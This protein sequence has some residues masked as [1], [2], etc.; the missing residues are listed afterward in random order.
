MTDFTLDFDQHDEYTTGGV[1]IPYW[2]WIALMQGAEVMYEGKVYGPD[3]GPFIIIAEEK[4]DEPEKLPA[5]TVNRGG[6]GSGHHEHQ[7][8][9]GEVGGSLPSGAATLPYNEPRKKGSFVS[10]NKD[11][12]RLISPGRFNAGKVD[13][14][15]VRIYYDH[16]KQEQKEI[17]VDAVEFLEDTLN[18]DLS[19]LFI[20][21]DRDMY[22]EFRK[23]K[24]TRLRTM[25]RESHEDQIALK[26]EWAGDTVWSRIKDLDLEGTFAFIKKNT[27]GIYDNEG[28][29]IFLNT[30]TLPSAKSKQFLKTLWHEIGH[31]IDNQTGHEWLPPEQ[32]RRVWAH[33]RV[34]ANNVSW[35]YADRVGDSYGYGDNLRKEYFADLTMAAV[36]SAFYNETPKFGRRVGHRP[37]SDLEQGDMDLLF[38]W[39]AN[40]S[41]HQLLL[42]D[43]EGSPVERAVDG[44]VMVS[45]EDGEGYR[46][47]LRVP[48]NEIENLPDTAIVLDPETMFD[49]GEADQLIERG[50]EGSGHHEHQGRPGEVGGSLPSGEIALDDEGEWKITEGEYAYEVYEDRLVEIIEDKGDNKYKVEVISGPERGAFYQDVYMDDLEEPDYDLLELWTADDIDST[51]DRAKEIFGLTEDWNEAGYILDDG[52]MLDFSGKNQGGS[53]GMRARDHREIGQ[54]FAGDKPSYTEGMVWFMDNARAI[55][56]SLNSG[57]LMVDFAGPPTRAQRELI[58]S[59]GMQSGAVYWDVSRWYDA[60]PETGAVG[61]HISIDSGETSSDLEEIETM[62]ESIRGIYYSPDY[63]ERS[64]V[65]RTLKQIINILRGGE[66][67]GHHGHAGRQGEVGGSLPS[68]EWKSKAQEYVDRLRHPAKKKYGQALIG[69]F[70]ANARGEYPPLPEP[71]QVYKKGRWTPTGFSKIFTD[72]DEIAPHPDPF[73]FV[74]ET[75]DGR[76]IGDDVPNTDSIS[77]SS[78]DYE[79]LPGIREVPFSA[80]DITGAPSFYSVSEREKTEALAEGIRE[81]GHI[82]PLIVMIDAEGPWILE[83]GHRFD[84]LLMLDAKSFPALVVI[85]NDP[86][87]ERGGPGSGHHGH[88]GRPGEV[89]GS[90]PSGAGLPKVEYLPFGEDIPNFWDM[91][92]KEQREGLFHFST[93]DPENSR[94]VIFRDMELA[95]DFEAQALRKLDIEKAEF[96]VSNRGMD[97]QKEGNETSVRFGF[98]EMNSIQA[99]ANSAKEQ[100]AEY[101]GIHNHP[102]VSGRG[103]NY[104]PSFS[105]FAAALQQGLTQFRVIVPDGV[106]VIDVNKGYNSRAIAK[107]RKQWAIYRDTKLLDYVDSIPDINIKTAWIDRF[108]ADSDFAHGYAAFQNDRVRDLAQTSEV[109]DAYFDIE[110]RPT[111]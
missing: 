109:F 15:G 93:I 20:I 38:Q 84:A 63:E 72:L 78:M 7:G 65:V 74:G 87:V 41:Q 24:L 53:A 99:A 57:D 97:F 25:A 96:F 9:P 76:T 98:W 46:E 58:E 95:L 82:V 54:A 40:E 89:G 71:D 12:F 11:P 81:S 32:D 61:H 19:D 77:A 100:G 79:V 8:R 51:I 23:D 75:V 101:I 52:E 59:I 34:V 92:K 29:Y 67:S 66:G 85:D 17:L 4:S 10:D 13:T 1:V 104:A 26:P 31:H 56:M 18:Y 37:L 33:K 48:L 110:W 3:D 14:R 68:G 21:T 50:G 22:V 70:E 28:K 107:I 36:S 6:P 62:L 88:K 90:L 2:H 16:D 73:P 103:L 42:G 35:K 80:F 108:K 45:F 111:K 64:W 47:E 86:I 91:R 69:V 106:W 55:R 44:S 102:D 43:I 49:L 105:D 39:I 5:F 27:N 94:Y 30:E 83:G 60:D